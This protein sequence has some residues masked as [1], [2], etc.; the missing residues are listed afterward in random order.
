MRIADKVLHSQ[1]KKKHTHTQTY[2]AFSVRI[3]KDSEE[4]HE[5]AQDR[6]AKHGQGRQHERA[7]NAPRR[8]VQ[9]PNK[10]DVRT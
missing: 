7:T 8:V 10:Q 5:V 6:R 9:S 3:D 4:S 2:F 1:M